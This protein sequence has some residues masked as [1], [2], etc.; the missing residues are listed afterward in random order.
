M[1]K[2]QS[3]C[4]I[5]PMSDF[6]TQPYEQWLIQMEKQGNLGF[7][8]TQFIPCLCH[9][10]RSHIPKQTESKCNREWNFCVLSR[11]GINTF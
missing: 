11:T 1:T 5:S 2:I 4:Q 9:D 7:D 3:F 10:S 6:G 8:I